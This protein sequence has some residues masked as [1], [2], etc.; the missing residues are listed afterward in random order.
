MAWQCSPH[1]SSTPIFSMTSASKHGGVLARGYVAR[2]L[3]ATGRGEI[4]GTEVLATARFRWNSNSCWEIN[5]QIRKAEQT[6]RLTF[7][8]EPGYINQHPFCKLC[9]KESTAWRFASAGRMTK[10]PLLL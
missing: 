1:C 5:V 6:K 7:R 2:L 9:P 3:I 8:I 4:H 10:C